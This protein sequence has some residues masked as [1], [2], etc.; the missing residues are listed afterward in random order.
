MS[1]RLARFGFMTPE[2]PPISALNTTPL[3]DVLL[4]LLIMFIVTIPIATHKV[5][6]D[7]PSGAPAVREEPLSHIL[8]LD[9]AGRLSWD[10]TPLAAADLAGRLSAFRAARPD[11]LLELRADGETRYDDVDRVLA[12]VKRS[13][14]A[15]M[16]FVG[17]E[18][19]AAAG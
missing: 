10:G 6:L 11:G 16:A 7:L 9:P 13:G 14:I 18:R 12:S 2:E 3:I 5:A 17:N 15:R 4:V 19:F 1:S 8:A